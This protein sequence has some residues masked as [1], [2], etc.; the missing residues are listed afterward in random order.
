MKSVR[1]LLGAV[2]LGA[3]LAV[4]AVAPT[5]RADVPAVAPSTSVKPPPRVRAKVAFVDVE[6]CIGETEDGLRAKAML[7]KFS[8]RRQ[9]VIAQVEDRLKRTQDELTEMAKNATSA[10]ARA[11]LSEAVIKHQKDLQSYNESIKKMN[12]EIAGR[13][14]ELYAP[15]EKKVKAIFARIGEAEGY[16]LILDKKNMPVG[17]PTFDLTERVIREYNWGK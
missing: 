14:D 3:S 15:I 17:K 7:K 10:E 12:M 13:E 2:V 6:R 5:L 8:D 9:M 1:T 16:D 11:K 4:V